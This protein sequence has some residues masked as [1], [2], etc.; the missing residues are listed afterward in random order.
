MNKPVL[1]IV[2]DDPQ[3]LAA[4]RRDLRSHY[5]ENYTVMGASSGGDALEAMRE[6][7]S[8]G[9]SLAMII[10]D[11]RMPGMMGSEVLAK[12]RAIYPLARRVLLTAY[13]DIDAAVKAIN[14][15][16]LDHYLSKPWDP[17][18]ERLFPAVDD[19]LD[20]W[21][22]ESLPEAKGLRLVGHQWSPQSHAIKDFLASN[23][24]PYRWLDVT[25]DEDAQALL[26]AAGVDS[27]ELPALFFDDG[28]PVL[29]N[30]DPRMV[31]ERLGRPLTATF[32]LYDLA[33]VGAGPAGLAAA[34][35]GASEG[36]RTVLL[37]RHAPC[38]QAGSSSRIENYLGFPAG[39]SGSELTRRAIAQAQRLGAEFLAP[40][41]TT[42]LSI[43]GGYKRLTLSDGRELVTRTVLASTGMLYR[44][45]PAPGIAELTGAGVYYGAATTEA[46]AFRERRVLVVGGGN[47]AGQAAMHLARYAREV[48]I[49]VRRDGLRE[50]MSQ[51]LIEQIEKTANIRVRIGSEVARVEGDGHVERVALTCLADGE[52]TLEDADALFIFIGTSPRSDWLPAEVLRDAKGFVLTGRDLMAADDFARTWKEQREPLLLE[53]SVPGVF[54][55]GDLRAGAMNRVASAVGEGSMVVRLAHEYLALT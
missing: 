18:E 41:E 51:Y 24:I 12:S 3:V 21:Q 39:V 7:K 32:D 30:P 34:V 17:P 53:T 31:A 37:D 5:R 47:S 1:M 36:L 6:L 50:T 25:R 10:S 16:H 19:L 55:A 35:Y 49:I 8:R 45:H 54:A 40:L 4:V 14:E 28:T 26:D 2:D 46:A 48:E 22:A 42:G 52:T 15:A 13:S 44:Q 9:D 27:S 20:G 43:D 33:I 38:G 29:R 11:Q 23:L